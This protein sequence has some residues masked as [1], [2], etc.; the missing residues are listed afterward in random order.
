M[1]ELLFKIWFMIAVLPY[2]IFLEANDMLIAYLKKKHIYWDIWY[3]ILV[4]F[5][6][7]CTI[8]LIGIS[9]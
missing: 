1:L 9:F 8:I 3:S 4:F 2:L 7:V 5:I 6:I